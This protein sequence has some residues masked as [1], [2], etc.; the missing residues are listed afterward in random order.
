LENWSKNC[1]Q[2]QN[3]KEKANYGEAIKRTKNLSAEFEKDFSQS[4]QFSTVLLDLSSR[5]NLHTQ[6]SR[7]WSH[8]RLIMRIDNLEAR[9]FYLT[10]ASQEN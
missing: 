2:E 4:S 6:C 8:N 5:I 9:H 7:S 3:G 10:E 1:Y